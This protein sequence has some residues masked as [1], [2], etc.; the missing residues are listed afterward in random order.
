M[1]WLGDAWD[2]ASGLFGGGSSSGSSS[3]GSGSGW[4][5][6]DIS[7]VI[8]SGRKIYNT[9][10]ANSSRQNSRND[11]LDFLKQTQGQDNAYN[12]QMW[13]YQNARSA[14]ARQAAA[15]ND[16]ERRKASAKAFKQQSKMLKELI[17]QYQPYNDAVQTLT[18]KMANN[19]S[20]YL[21]TTALLNQYLTPKAMQTLNSA[22]TPSWQ[23]GAP[24]E[25]FAAPA[26]Q[27]AEVSF[28]SLD[29]VLK[30]K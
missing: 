13:E 7:K 28:P 5:W 21:D 19:Y 26:V 25:A 1:T 2:W 8:D 9:W 30:R 14:A 17:K 18:P 12:Q 27:S 6:N 29:E 23:M 15:A 10:D 3:S 24:R 16:A 4:N 20:Q 11:I 22:P